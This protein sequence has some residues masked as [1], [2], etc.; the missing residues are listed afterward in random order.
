[1]NH[2]NPRKRGQGGKTATSNQETIDAPR[3]P[4]IPLGD[5]ADLHAYVRK[6]AQT[7]TQNEDDLEELADE[8][9]ALAY[10][11]QTQ[12]EPGE[13]LQQ[14]LSSWLESRL[15]DHW[16]KQHPEWRRNSRAATAYTLQTPT[17]L[18]WEQHA[19]TT[20]GMPAAD[21]HGV[22]ESRL[23]LSLITSAKDLRNPRI[24]GHFAGVP[25]H[26]ALPTGRADELWATIEQERDLTRS[27]PFR[28]RK[29]DL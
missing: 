7:I 28:F 24:T 21:C 20:T 2:A 23:N 11:R 1:V 16:R 26:A 3:I 29:H 22:I 5:I 4:T 14:A 10:Q 9:I 18:S 8:G 27:K 6:I 19:G 17:G 13:S 15:R 12:L 25:S